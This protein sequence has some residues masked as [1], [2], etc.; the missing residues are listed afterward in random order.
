MTES[1]GGEGTRAGAS[2]R[3]SFIVKSTQQQKSAARTQN[4]PP[5]VLDWNC[6]LFFS[7]RSTADLE[8]K[9]CVS[10]ARLSEVE[11]KR[12]KTASLVENNTRRR[13]LPS[14]FSADFH[15]F[16]R[17][18]LHRGW[19]WFKNGIKR[20]R[21]ELGGAHYR[22][23]LWSIERNGFFPLLSFAFIEID[24]RSMQS[25]RYSIR[26]WSLWERWGASCIDFLLPTICSGHLEKEWNSRIL[27]SFFVFASLGECKFRASLTLVA[28]LK[29]CF[30]LFNVTFFK[31][32][33]RLLNYN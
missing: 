5:C 11:K 3:C 1:V 15:H 25:S 21:R 14:C 12:G 20:E 7:P 26:L 33:R 13:R 18:I 30:V 6:T 27:Q 28:S 4:F 24:P 10:C 9:L 22:L 2:E 29:F 19:T 31:N 32:A 16:A 23:C 17:F 8:S